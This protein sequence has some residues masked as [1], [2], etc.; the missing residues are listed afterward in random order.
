V[1]LIIGE[2]AKP[3]GGNMAKQQSLPEMD[4]ERAIP[5]LTEAAE[6]YQAAKEKR[7]KALT[8]ELEKREQVTTLM[9]KHKLRVYRD[10]DLFVVLEDKVKVK[11]LK[12]EGSE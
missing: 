11:H 8:F 2:R 12:E 10:D 6:E 9:K 1:V 3:K 4:N 7:M 5:A